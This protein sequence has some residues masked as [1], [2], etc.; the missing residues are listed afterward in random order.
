[1]VQL[2]GVRVH[3][4]CS[5][6]AR[7]LDE[8]SD[9]TVVPSGNKL[10]AERFI[11][12]TTGLKFQIEVNIEPSFELWDADGIYIRVI[13]DGGVVKKAIFYS[14][15]QVEEQKRTSTPFIDGSAI[16]QEGSAWCKA[17]YSFG[18]LNIGKSLKI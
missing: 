17:M 1:M 5:S 14:K 8:Y 12:A 15:E 4:V 13:I 2:Q 9:I 3:V 16:Y 6:S 10:L 11:E 18:S 7:V